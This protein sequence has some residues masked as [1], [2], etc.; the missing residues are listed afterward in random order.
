MLLKFEI[1]IAIFWIGIFDCAR[2]ASADPGFRGEGFGPYALLDGQSTDQYLAVG[3]IIFS[4]GGFCTGT[5]H[6]FKSR[7]LWCFFI[8][9]KQNER[10]KPRSQ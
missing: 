4:T 7:Y 6:D 2:S 1:I 10:R 5:V 3:K 9:Q 8:L